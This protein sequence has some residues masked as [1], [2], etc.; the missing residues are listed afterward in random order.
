MACLGYSYCWFPGGM[1]TS[2]LYIKKQLYFGSRS[3]WALF[4]PFE[5]PGPMDGS[6]ARFVLVPSSEGM[7]T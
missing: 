3:T 5:A 2:L 4:D 6:V 7:G 1:G